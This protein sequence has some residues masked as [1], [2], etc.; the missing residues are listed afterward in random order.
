MIS[1]FLSKKKELLNKALEDITG[2]NLI[3]SGI[4]K[5]PYL[6][7]TFLKDNGQLSCK[8]AVKAHAKSMN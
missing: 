6:C 7:F 3:L 5:K 4:K 8:V 2:N 1:R